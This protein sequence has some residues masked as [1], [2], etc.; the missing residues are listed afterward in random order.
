MN[1]VERGISIDAVR[2]VLGMTLTLVGSVRRS[3]VAATVQRVQAVAYQIVCKMQ[4]INSAA[5]NSETL[6]NFIVSVHP[7]VIE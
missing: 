7:I 6:D 2:R 3:I 4:T 1:V 5:S